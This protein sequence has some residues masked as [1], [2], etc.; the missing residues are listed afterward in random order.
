MLTDLT[1]EV[2]IEDMGHNVK[3]YD[4]R[5][6][7]YV[8]GAAY[9][10]YPLGTIHMVMVD[11]FGGERPAIA[12]V[13]KDGH[14]FVAP[15][16]G[17]LPL[18]F[19]AETVGA[20]QYKELVM[21]GFFAEWIS[22]AGAIIAALIQRGVGHT[23]AE[24][25][26]RSPVILHPKLLQDGL[27]CNI[28]YIDRFENVVLDITKPEFEAVIGDKPIRIRMPR[29]DDITSLSNNYNDVD[30]GMPL[31]RFNVADYL[32]IAV[33]R[34]GAASLLGLSADNISNLRYRTIRVFTGQQ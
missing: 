18:S 30:E 32:E 14:Y 25:E 29:M 9:R 2:I 34:G 15:D 26:L 19:Q 11:V 21:P 27:E 7:A 24:I 12:L 6:A 5:Q 23:S 3:P 10:H 13:E 16:N 33:N 1:P 4:L 31:A 20:W 28:L 22:D 17:V 8:L